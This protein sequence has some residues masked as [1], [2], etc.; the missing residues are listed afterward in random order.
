MDGGEGV[1][2]KVVR[3][4]LSTVDEVIRGRDKG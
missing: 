4:G 2:R 1:G 3:S